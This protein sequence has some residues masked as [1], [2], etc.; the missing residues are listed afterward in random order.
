MAEWAQIPT[1]TLLTSSGKLG[2]LDFSECGAHNPSASSIECKTRFHVKIIQANFMA[3][4]VKHETKKKKKKFKNGPVTTPPP[5]RAST[6]CPYS[7]FSI[8]K[9]K[10][11]LHLSAT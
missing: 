3:S 4:N 9:K 11:W 1:V 2:F 7:G 10:R 6:L 8:L 5:G